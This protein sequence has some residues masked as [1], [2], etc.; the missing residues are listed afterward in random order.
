VYTAG[1]VV[2]HEVSGDEV[3]IDVE[4]PGRLVERYREHLL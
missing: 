4:I 3:R 1:R 2:S